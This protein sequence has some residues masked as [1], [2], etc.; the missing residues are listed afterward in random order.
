MGG[1]GAGTARYGGGSMVRDVFGR[2]EDSMP[3]RGRARMA[4]ALRHH[5]LLV[6][7]FASIL[8]VFGIAGS[9]PSVA[10]GA[11]VPGLVAP[12]S[13]VFEGGEAAAGQGAALFLRQE[14]DDHDLDPA[15]ERSR[16]GNGAAVAGRLARAG[17]GGTASPPTP[18]AWP[19]DDGFEGP[20]VRETLPIGMQIDRYGFEGGTFLSPKGTPIE[21]RSLAPGTTAKPYNIYEVT[22]P[23]AVL[24]GKTA[25]WFG[26]PGGGIQYELPMPV[27]EAISEGYLKRMGQ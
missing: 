12:R 26:Q 21:M 6:A 27:T 22:K 9:S 5:V 15:D 23:I 1:A 2:W 11:M 13:P 20:A 10:A 19:P 4:D 7:V 17:T 14:A 18:I 25:P 24:S 3:F 16:G 8:T